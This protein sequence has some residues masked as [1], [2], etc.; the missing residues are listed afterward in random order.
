LALSKYGQN[1]P[2]FQG[3]ALQDAFF[4]FLSNDLGVKNVKRGQKKLTRDKD[5]LDPEVYKIKKEKDKLSR[6]KLELNENISNFNEQ[7][8]AKKLEI[9]QI[10]IQFDIERKKLHKEKLDFEKYKNN[11]IHDLHKKEELNK[12]N[13]VI[14]FALEK[15]FEG[16]I[17]VNN[18]E[19][20]SDSSS[21]YYLS[22]DPELMLDEQKHIHQILKPFIE[23]VKTALFFFEDM[24][25]EM[26]LTKDQEYKMKRQNVSRVR[27]NL[28]DSGIDF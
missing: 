18:R 11:I 26:R 20:T 14:G 16:K 10:N 25:R 8:K 15:Y 22:F 3:R 5:R 19:N 7:V 1:S 24:F 13:F 6:V 4:E 21:R 9:S 27:S 2:A 12:K 23:S 17:Y 28:R